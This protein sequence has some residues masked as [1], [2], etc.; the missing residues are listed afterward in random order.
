M[1]KDDR[2]H[3]HLGRGKEDGQ[4]AADKQK[5]TPAHH[6]FFK[7]MTERYSPHSCSQ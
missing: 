4:H 2:I 3:L 6:P 5:E 7:T 1:G